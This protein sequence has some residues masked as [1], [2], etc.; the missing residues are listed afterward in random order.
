MQSKILK[1]MT[2][3]PPVRKEKHCK[4][5]F[6]W[7]KVNIFPLFSN[8]CKTWC[9]IRM[10]IGME[11]EIHIRIRIGMEMEIQIRIRIGSKTMLIGNIGVK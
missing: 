9:K 11:M 5:P 1:I 2:P 8:M 7:E 3:M 10:W 6:L 4:L